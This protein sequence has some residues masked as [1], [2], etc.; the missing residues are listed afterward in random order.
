MNIFY[1]SKIKADQLHHESITYAK[2]ST[3]LNKPL[4]SS[5]LKTYGCLYPK[6]GCICNCMLQY[7]DNFLTV[8]ESIIHEIRL[9]AHILKYNQ[10]KF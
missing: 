2:G 10:S 5:D 9:K 1:E 7:F 6:V 8:Y 3:L 4:T